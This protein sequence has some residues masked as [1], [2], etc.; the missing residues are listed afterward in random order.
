MHYQAAPHAEVKLVRC[1]RGSLYDVIVDL[2]TDSPTFRKCL[3]VELTAD[4][5]RMLY[6]PERFAHG[7]IT[8]EDQTE[9]F[10]QMSEYYAP[11]SARGFRWDDPS[12]DIPLPHEIEIIS[13]RDRS[14]PDFSLQ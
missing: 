5:R 8:L 3:G 12:F 7:F 13:D 10:Y 11:Q 2:R 4:N 1:T 14:Y 6:V 9:I